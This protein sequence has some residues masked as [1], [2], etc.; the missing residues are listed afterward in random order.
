MKN[1]IQY[2]LIVI[3]LFVY[4]AARAQRPTDTLN[5]L[6][7]TAKTPVRDRMFIV[8]QESIFQNYTLLCKCL[9]WQSNAFFF[10]KLSQKGFVISPDDLKKIKLSTLNQ[11]IHVAA[12][13]G[14]YREDQ[15]V[16]FFIEKVGDQYIKHQVHLGKPRKDEIM[17]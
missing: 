6:V 9:T 17:Y 12:D 10:R 4:N 5:Y 11:L 7:D 8:E 16:F 13:Y 2:L 14:I 15:T 1:S 3:A